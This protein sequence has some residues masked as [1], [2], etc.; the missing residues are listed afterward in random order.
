M[1]GHTS[2]LTLLLLNEALYYT[3]N[4]LEDYPPAFKNIIDYSSPIPIGST[5]LK[6]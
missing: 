6:Q 3:K 2:Q 5:W 1:N 4:Y